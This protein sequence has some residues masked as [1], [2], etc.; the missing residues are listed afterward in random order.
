[1][2]LSCDVIRD[3]LPLYADQA[4]SANTAAL[5]EETAARVWTGAGGARSGCSA[6]SS[7]TGWAVMARGSS[8]LVE[9][10]MRRVSVASGLVFSA[11]VVPSG[12][13]VEAPPP[14][15]AA[16]PSIMA[17]ASRRADSFFFI[18]VPSF[19]FS[20]NNNRQYGNR[21]AD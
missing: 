16:R 20:K 1:M 21:F 3:L 17:E 12:A 11:G 5:V 7:A 6:I 4:A 19:P 2:K 15:Q 13:G 14:P 18:T 10:P 9:M 8:S